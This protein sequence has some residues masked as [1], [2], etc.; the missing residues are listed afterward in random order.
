MDRA[1]TRPFLLPVLLLLVA[2]L[3]L[4]CG[5]KGDPYPRKELHKTGAS[6]AAPKAAQKAT[7][8]AAPEAA[9]VPVPEAPAPEEPHG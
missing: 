3:S 4:G 7:P 9:P 2:A 8:E 1:N 6:K 5:R